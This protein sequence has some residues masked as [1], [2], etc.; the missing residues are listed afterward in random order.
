MGKDNKKIYPM[1]IELNETIKS[2]IYYISL[3]KNI[4]EKWIELEK[5]SS[6]KKLYNLPTITLKNILCSYFEG[7][8]EMSVVSEYSDDTK[9]LVCFKQI[10][11]EILKRCFMTWIDEFY[12][13]GKIEQKS[14]R[15]NGSDEK[16]KE[17]TEELVQMI[18]CCDF[19]IN[20]EK[21][22]ILFENGVAVE[23][24]AFRLFPMKIIDSLIGKNINIQGKS[25]KL[26]YSSKNEIVTDTKVFESEDDYYSF[27]IKLS[28]Q[29]L[30][31]DNKAYLNV[32]VSVRRWICRNEN[33]EGTNY[34]GNNKNCYIR[35]RDDRMQC[36]KTQYNSEKKMNVW[37]EID[38]KC[39]EECQSKGE[40]PNFI[41]VLKE[42]MRYNRG[43][44]KDVLVPFQEGLRDIE[45]NV[46]NGITF[47]DREYFFKYIK[48]FIRENYNIESNVEAINISKPVSKS[49][50]DFYESKESININSEYFVEQLKRAVAGEKVSIEIFAIGDLKEVLIENLKNYLGDA[51]NELVTLCDYT[52]IF[53]QLEIL[54]PKKNIA[55]FESRIE[56]ISKELEYTNVPTISFV[57]LHDAKYYSKLRTDQETKIKSDVDPKNAIRAGFAK[58]GRL[59]QFITFEEFEKQEENIKSANE[60]YNK[61]K[62]KSLENGTK[63]KKQNKKDNVNKALDGAILDG[64]RQLG[65]LFDYESNKKMKDKTIYGIHV[66]NFKTTLYGSIKPFPI[67]IKYDASKSNIMAYCELV[68]KIEIPYWKAIL[69]ISKLSLEKD[70]AEVSKSI[71][72]TTINRRLDRII[73]KEDENVVIIVEANGTVRNFLKGISNS[74]IQ[75]TTRNEFNQI[76]KLLITDEKYLDLDNGNLALI[77]I[78]CN[79]E[80]PSYLVKEKNDE[81]YSNTS[82][83]FKYG[84][85]Y[86]SVDAKSAGEKDSYDKSESKALTGKRYSHR[87]MVEVYPMYVSGDDNNHEEN[88]KTAVGIVHLLRGTSIQFTSQMTVLP[89]PLHLASKME[90]YIL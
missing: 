15:K 20:I 43:K 51:Y 12:M 42:P 36:I 61:R 53:D 22:A 37:D 29:T 34:I 44:Q 41:E 14:K 21:E 70:L 66:C 60:K 88:E 16:V 79:D 31:P 68:D 3:P 85:V 63:I 9:W 24:N 58:T 78:R 10:D 80:I 45:T 47:E 19:Q 18:K 32:D 76:K 1:M 52:E 73:N 4:K 90:E 2:D 82:G 84:K 56:E 40:L 13:N 62:E 64:F 83:L 7:I 6:N 75:E 48:Q 30:P 8:V 33:K 77:R 11:I 17:L 89:L 23:N 25:A 46:D 49:N 74:K 38:L 87:K 59:T 39:F 81:M 50:N 65:V 28:V 72:S 67:I 86:Y 35:I 54:A 71:S 26:L 57:A 27:V 5:N 69:G 55:G